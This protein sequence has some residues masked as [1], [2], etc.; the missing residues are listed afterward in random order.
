MN[1]QPPPAPEENLETRIE[2]GC[3]RAL[4]IQPGTHGT[5]RANM[6]RL[7]WVYRQQLQST[8]GEKPPGDSLGGVICTSRLEMIEQPE[9]TGHLSP[10]NGI[11]EE[12]TT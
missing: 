2:A 12:M 11:K 10:L 9:S 7:V 1:K 5:T 3:E 4:W 6:P 8:Q